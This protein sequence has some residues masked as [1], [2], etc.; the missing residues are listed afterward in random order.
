V[1]SGVRLSALLAALAAGTGFAVAMVEA[2][3]GARRWGRV[4]GRRWRAGSEGRAR[5][6][7][8]PRRDRATRT[9]GS[10]GAAARAGPGAS[11]TLPV[12]VQ[13]RREATYIAGV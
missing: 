6:E 12:K 7:W 3:G 13:S 4:R 5:R 11:P 8:Q 1:E 9:G 2:G 10:A